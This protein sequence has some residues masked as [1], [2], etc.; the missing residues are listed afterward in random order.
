MSTQTV[1]D[2][3][4][5]EVLVAT[6]TTPTYSAPHNG[7]IGDASATA[8][9]GQINQFL[10]TH[11]ITAI[12]SGNAIGSGIQ[13]FVNAPGIWLAN[14][15]SID[16]DQPFTM[17]GT[18]IGRVQIPILPVGDGADL[19]VSLCA[20]NAGSPGTVIVQTRVPASWIYQ[21]SA[22]AGTAT[23]TGAPTIAY[24]G[25]PLAT[26]QFLEFLH[27][28]VVTTPYP[29]PAR[30]GIAAASSATWYGGYVIQIGGVNG[31]IALPSVYTIP[32]SSGGVLSPSI[33]QPDFPVPNDGSSASC[34]AMDAVTGSPVVVNCGGGTSFG[35]APVASAYTATLDTTNGTLSAW[36][37]QASLPYAVQS[38]IMAASG[39]YVYSIGG[40]N[41]G[42]T[43]A[44]VSYAQVQNAQITGWT[45]T[46]PL[47]IPVELTFCGVSNGFLFV[48]AGTTSA[49][50]P[51]YT[52]VWFAAI[53]SDGSLGG[54]RPGPSMPTGDINQNANA[55]ANDYGL[56]FGSSALSCLAVTASGPA[57][58]W[59]Q[60]APGG[61]GY[62]PGWYDAGNGTVSSASQFSGSSLSYQNY[63]APSVSVPLPATGLT[64]GATYHVLMQQQSGDLNN[65][66]IAA[67][68]ALTGTSARSSPRGTYT[69][70]T[71]PTSGRPIGSALTVYD[72]APSGGT[73]KPLH[74][75]SDNG[76]RI[77]TIVSATT[78][79]QRLLGIC[80][81]T[82]QTTALNSNT[83]FESGITPWTVTGGAGVQSTTEVYQGRYA[84]QITPSGSAASVIAASE[85]MP[86]MPGQWCTATGWAWFTNAVTSNFSMSIA[87]YSAVSGGT[88]LSVSAA[89]VS[90]PAATYTQEAQSLQAP[91]G[92]YGFQIQATLSGTPSSSQLWFLDSSRAHYTYAGPQNATVAE[93]GAAG[94]WPAPTT[95][96]GVTQLA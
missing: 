92:A 47:P 16:L 30:V 41:S 10:G 4:D 14:L 71:W 37:S 3:N 11:G 35:G 57:S 6:T 44:N 8:G 56:I 82:R 27:G 9:A 32:Y 1:P 25:N 73:G 70:T 49:L 95:P 31:G 80:E 48:C 86:C 38:N 33:P 75:W 55:F 65:Y 76:A 77:T 2:R 74:L 43:L 22:L 7:I 79:D 60:R 59:V 17:S 84:L 5:E 18:S 64:N 58:Y 63:L 93:V 36:S 29:T 42:G 20:D 15:E 26:A 66:L 52:N 61:I 54:W 45:Q 62:Y 94:N 51:T 89:P 96:T 72:G 81:A 39:A 88:Q 40:T 85:I 28:Q 21:L 50:T 13:P 69:W 19:L 68:V 34:V 67:M 90:V 78:P 12:Y 87:W 53:N 91:T 24:T 83:G 23:G 46:T